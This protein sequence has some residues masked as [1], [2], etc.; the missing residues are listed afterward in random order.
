MDTE[1]QTVLKKCFLHKKTTT[2]NENFSN[3]Q[4]VIDFAIE[5][6]QEAHDFYMKT[7]ERVKSQELKD[8]LY[9]FA[10]EELGHKKKLQNIIVKTEEYGFTK[11]DVTHLKIADYLVDK[12]PSSDMSYQDI[13]II[14]MKKEK[15]SYLLYT[16]LANRV[17][18]EELKKIFN[19]LA[20]EEA[21]HKLRFELEYDEHILTDN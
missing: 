21:S 8:M 5:R 3:P 20:Q 6:E 16:D 11:D 15:K 4:E 9:Q 18:N 19:N 14:S 1:P 7:R 13:L 17:S 2:M 12:T 10:Q